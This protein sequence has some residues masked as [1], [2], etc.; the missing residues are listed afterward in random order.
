LCTIAHEDTYNA[1]DAP[2]ADGRIRLYNDYI[3]QT[4]FWGAADV[5]EYVTKKEIDF[6]LISE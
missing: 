3:W 1:F 5:K 2:R 4:K 6:S